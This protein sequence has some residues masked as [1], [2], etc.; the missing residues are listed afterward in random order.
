MAPFV[1]TYPP[2][3][4]MVVSPWYPA[5][6]T[7]TSQRQHAWCLLQ[8]GPQHGGSASCDAQLFDALL[9]ADFQGCAGVCTI[10]AHADADHD[11]K[12]S[13]RRALDEELS[14]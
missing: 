1:S 6:G 3:H 11:A 7:S 2:Y 5:R 12:R 9:R 8:A 14:L 10:E 4:S 13:E